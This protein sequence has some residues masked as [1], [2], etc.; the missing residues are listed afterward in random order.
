MEI[1]V[2]NSSVFFQMNL[3][4]QAP[5]I[6]VPVY[7]FTGKYDYYNPEEILAKYVD[8]LEAP[9]KT[10]YSFDC[11]AHAPHFEAIVD[12]AERMKRVKL[13]TFKK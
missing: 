13:D 1:F 11:C 10:F 12:F 3:F 9:K 8:V 7:F 4:K 2:Q 6:L 5:S